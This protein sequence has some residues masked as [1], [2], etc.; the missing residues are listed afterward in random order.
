MAVEWSQGAGAVHP[1]PGWPRALTAMAVALT[2]LLVAF[3]PTF[4]SMVETWQRSETFAHG[5]LIVPIVAFL[6]FRLR[7]ELASLQP[8]PCLLAVIPLVLIT[9]MW[10]MGELVDVISVR[11]F[12]AVL[13]VPTLVWL[14]LGSEITRRLQFPLAYL[15]FAVPFGE[16][17]VEPM[18]IWT[19]DFTV[20]AIRLTGVPVYR[21]GLYFDLPTGR[22]SVVAACSGVRYLIASVALGTLFAYLMYR[23]WTRRLIFVAIAILVPIVANWLRAYGIV[24][25][26]HLSDMRLA[27]GVDHLLYGWVFFGV[28]ILLMFLIGA[29]WREDHLSTGQNSGDKTPGTGVAEPAPRTGRLV[30]AT[31]LALLLT[32]SGP[33]YAGWMNH[34]D[35][36]EVQG[37]GSGPLLVEGWQAASEADAEPWT[38]GYRNARASRGGLV[39]Q[40]EAGHAVGLH[41]DYYRAQHRHGNM[42]GWANTLAGRHRDDWRQHSG[43]RTA[44]PGIDRQGD[45]V[46]LSGP[47]GRR[48]VAWRWYWVGGRLTTSGHEVKAREALSRLLGGRDDAALVVLYADYRND[49]AEAEAALAQY[50]AQAL[51]QALRLLDGV[52]GP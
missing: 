45:R 7:H 50:A 51:P 38:P 52:A 39:V 29:L 44:V 6:V 41:I 47:D 13:M 37:L 5:F 9:L 46:L 48:V 19:A 26:G 32:V 27:A 11:Q 43:G 4:T 3:F 35:L 40:E 15:L 23:S 24:M 16:F 22:W 31:A 30:T 12:A 18:M 2:A 20:A 28:V 25:I 17:M 34:R 42:V 36:G 14:V 1:A 49:P 10:V 21:D 33:L 8:R